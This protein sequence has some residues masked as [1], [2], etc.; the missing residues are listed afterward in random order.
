[1][2]VESQPRRRAGLSTTAPYRCVLGLAVTTDTPQIKSARQLRVIGR[3]MFQEPFSHTKTTPTAGCSNQIV[4][5]VTSVTFSARNCL[6]HKVSLLR[7]L[8][9]CAGD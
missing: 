5:S 3:P 9:A 7:L 6:F 8:V 4:A 2:P 1:V